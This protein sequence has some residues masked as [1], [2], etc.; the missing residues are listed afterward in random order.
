MTKYTVKENQQDEV[1]KDVVGYEGIYQVSNFGR[2]KSLGNGVTRKEKILRQHINRRG[3][4]KLDLSMK[5]QEPKKFSVH[6]LVAQAF[7]PN[8]LNKP[9]VNHVNCF[10]SDNRVTNLEWNTQ[11]ENLLHAKANGLG[12]QLKPVTAINLE[13]NERLEFISQAE[14]SRRLGLNISYILSGRAKKNIKGWKIE[15]KVS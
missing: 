11:K 4:M 12:K 2:V 9:Q 3:Y 7:I 14:A 8:P 6:R 15:C 5:G 1:W 13:T 10:K